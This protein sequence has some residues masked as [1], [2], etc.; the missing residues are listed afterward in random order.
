[1]GE[2]PLPL[3]IFGAAVVFMIVIIVRTR[4]KTGATQVSQAALDAAPPGLPGDP[5]RAGGRLDRNG[6][7]HG[8]E[9]PGRALRPRR[10]SPGPGH[11]GKPY[12]GRME[13]DDGDDRR[14]AV[15]GWIRVEWAEILRLR[16]SA[17]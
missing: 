12:G 3:V 16:S 8:G 1:M 7:P 15:G 2:I 14:P 10:R 5:G 17:S 13:N 4:M 9:G 11:H 6:E